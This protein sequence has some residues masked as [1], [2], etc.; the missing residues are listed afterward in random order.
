MV[1]EGAG[2]KAELLS[3]PTGGA[4]PQAVANSRKSRLRPDIGLWFL[5]L[6]NT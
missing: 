3:E 6:D 1:G 5:Y 4:V 2:V